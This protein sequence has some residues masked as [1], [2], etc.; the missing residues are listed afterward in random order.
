MITQAVTKRLNR[1]LSLLLGL[2]VLLPGCHSVPSAKTDT[3][4]SPNTLYE[5]QQQA[6][7]LITPSDTKRNAA[8]ELVIARANSVLDSEQSFSITFNQ[9]T[10]PNDNP[11]DYTSTGP[12]WWPNPDTANGLPWIRRDGIVNREVRG[13]DTDSAELREFVKAVNV[14]AQAYSYTKNDA[15]AQ[16]AQ[17][18]FDVFLFDKDTSM[19][20]NF[21]YAQAIPGIT[22]GRGIGIIESRLFINALNAHQQLTA[23]DH[24]NSQVSE[25]LS[26]WVTHYL[27]WLLT[28]PNGLDESRTHNNHASF[29]DYQVAY[30]ARFT[31]NEMVLNQVMQALYPQ[32]IQTQIQPGGAQPHELA[33]TRPYHYSV[34]N[35]EAFWGLAAIATDLNQP[36]LAFG[37]TDDTQV[38]LIVQAL[39]YLNQQQYTLLTQS[40]YASDSVSR[41][42][43]IRVNLIAGQLYDQRFS[44]YAQT[45]MAQHAEYDCLLAFPV[46][47]SNATNTRSPTHSSTEKN[48]DAHTQGDDGLCQL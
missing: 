44:A 19:N 4:I 14:L 27:H 28:S 3:P 10:P 31:D 23:S 47:V 18:L 35:L 15:Y 34:F 13:R 48:I 5:W 6:Q 25:P 22:D 36:E 39:D 9:A 45:L 12:Y 20:P 21:R 11:Q 26:R 41:E 2:T 8:R 32:R 24:Y 38:P 33:R 30:F 29:Y 37:P 43:L 17:E 16:R 46:P 42:S 1:R 40:H 7:A